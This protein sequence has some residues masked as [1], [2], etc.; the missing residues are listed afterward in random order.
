MTMTRPGLLPGR[1]AGGG[2][3]VLM[4]VHAHPDDECSQTGGTLARYAAAGYR[5]V[6]VTCTDGGQGEGDGG[7]KPCG[8]VTT[9]RRSRGGGPVSF[10]SPPPC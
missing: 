1:P 4:A 5:T 2:R 8:P 6:L 7:A 3:P 9:L 10:G